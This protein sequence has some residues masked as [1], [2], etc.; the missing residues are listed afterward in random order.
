MEL[1]KQERNIMPTTEPSNSFITFKTTGAVVSFETTKTP[2]LEILKFV[3]R[4]CRSRI[5]SVSAS[6]SSHTALGQINFVR[7]VKHVEH[8][9]RGDSLSWPE[10]VEYVEDEYIDEML[11]MEILEGR[12]PDHIW[13]RQ[14]QIEMKVC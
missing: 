10:E 1:R 12:Y 4:H 2:V 11:D 5:L 14:W 9:L 13:D 7:Y 8:F 6:N 3:T